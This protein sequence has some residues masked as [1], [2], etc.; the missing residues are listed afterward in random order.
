[1]RK[2]IV[3]AVIGAAILAAAVSLFGVMMASKKDPPRQPPRAMVPKVVAPPVRE[4]TDFEVE[5]VGYGSARP[6]KTVKLVAEVDGPVE[7][8]APELLVGEFVSRNT[9]L[10]RVEATDYMLAWEAADRQISLLQARIDVLRQEQ[11]NLQESEKIQSE[12]AK[13]TQAQLD[14]TLSL[15]KQGAA[16]DIEVENDRQAHLTA[17]QA[18][19]DIR[20]QLQLIQPQIDQIRAEK[21]TVEVQ[22]AQALVSLERT[23][24]RAP[25]TGRVLTEDIATGERVNRGQVCGE[26]YRMDVMEVPVSI[27]AGD[28]RWIGRAGGDDAVVADPGKGPEVVVQWQEGDDDQP[29]AWTRAWVDRV[30]PGLDP[31]TRTATLVVQVR[32]DPN[33]LVSA[34]AMLD[35]NG[36]PPLDVNMFCRV[37]MRGVKVPRAFLL[38]RSAIRPDG[39]VYIVEDGRLAQRQ[40]RV[41]RFSG[42][43][44]MVLPGGGIEEGMRVICQPLGRPVLGMKLE[45]VGQSKTAV[46]AEDANAPGAAKPDANGASE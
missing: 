13:I 19:Q 11:K 21:D 30:E 25:I 37:T 43:E 34:F 14:R 24:H 6:L 18:L 22:E 29:V 26:L 44:A 23:V 27:P 16:S 1:M 45:T 38:P 8:T 41:A 46:C 42:D 33:A 31:A 5:I 10:F 12:R 2:I 40:V 9:T 4:V 39:T 35:R 17:R 36:K 20:N 15:F 32:N 3:T 28:L 7:F